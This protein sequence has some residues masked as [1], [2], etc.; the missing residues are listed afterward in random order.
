MC[1]NKVSFP[2]SYGKRLSGILEGG[3]DR[4][5]VFCTHFTGFKEIRHYYRLAKRISELGM[6]SL[7]FDYSDCIGESDGTCEDMRLS[8]QVMDTISAIDL[9]ESLGVDRIGLFG[10]SLGG[11]TAIVTAANDSRVAA[12]VSAAAP[13]KLD[14]DTLFKERA[15]EWRRKGFISFPS[16]KRGDVKI[17]YDFYRDL[18]KYDATELVKGISA[19]ILVI[20]PGNDELVTVENARSMFD[21]ANEPKSI[22]FI[23]GSDHMF[24][25]ADH[26]SRMIDVSV[27][28]FDKWL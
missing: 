15:E 22:E 27:N 11:A 4:G 8:N 10:H 1:S 18:K 17:R 21:N 13:A 26:E 7:R 3:G 25:S 12:I 23:D 5:V 6:Y 19:P 2:N 16:W 20:Q 28:W 24:T 14:W 9:M